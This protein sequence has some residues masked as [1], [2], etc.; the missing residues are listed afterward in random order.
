MTLIDIVKLSLSQMGEDTGTSEID[1][2]GMLLIA[3]I[4]EAYMEICREKKQKYFREN[5][6]F[7]DFRADISSLSEDV[8]SILDIKS[9]SGAKICFEIIGDKIFLIGNEEGE[10]IVEYLYLPERLSEDTDEPDL[11]E[12]E[13]Y[14]LADFATYRGLALGSPS[15]QKRAEFF[16]MRYLSGYSSLGQRRNHI[17]NKY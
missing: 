14:L 2:Y 1:E 16:L 10:F 17:V 4:N 11:T 15:R 9:E 7:S 12:R 5:L 3:Y 8:F 6:D 13:C